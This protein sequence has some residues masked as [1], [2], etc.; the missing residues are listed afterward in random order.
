MKRGYLVAVVAVCVLT[1]GAL[2]VPSLSVQSASLTFAGGIRMQSDMYLYA[3]GAIVAP[4]LGD[5]SVGVG[6]NDGLWLGVHGFVYPADLISGFIGAEFQP[7][8]DETG[9]IAFSPALAAGFAVTP[10]GSYIVLEALILPVPVAHEVRVL[11]GVSAMFT[12]G[13]QRE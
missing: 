12:F 7:I 10:P 1:I 9:V 11:F 3:Q 2:S 5:V 8:R 4:G 6:L 13:G